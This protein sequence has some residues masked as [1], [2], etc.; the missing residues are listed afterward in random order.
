MPFLERTVLILSYLQFE[1]HQDVNITS[2]PDS[3]RRSNI[4]FVTIHR[5]YIWLVYT[6]ASAIPEGNERPRL[7]LSFDTILGDYE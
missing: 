7:N 3:I 6:V 4:K 2:K 1:R 5:S